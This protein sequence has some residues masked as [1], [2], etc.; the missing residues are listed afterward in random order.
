MALSAE[1]LPGRPR[2]ISEEARIDQ[3]IKTAGTISSGHFKFA[4][5]RHSNTYF[6]KALILGDAA[7]AAE[8]SG[9]MARPFQARGIDV[10]VGP[11]VG[12]VILS[13]QVALHLSH[14][15]G[16]M[17]P[18]V[19][20]EKREE[21]K[22]KGVTKGFSLKRDFR[23]L[24]EGKRVLLVEDVVTTGGSIE[25][26]LEEI[27]AAGAEPVAITALLKRG[28]AALLDA[29]QGVEFRSLKKR[30]DLLDWEQ[31]DCQPCKDGV[32]LNTTLGHAKR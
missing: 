2:I 1:S 14:M 4:S 29:I 26:L 15:E 18:G 5:E 31:K 21:D 7:T 10:V 13:H 23:E 28:S 27:K 19:F 11:A 30:P 9:Y 24:V 8:V 12:A 3:I 6:N 32:P 16:K 17:I 22:E 20:A 25:H